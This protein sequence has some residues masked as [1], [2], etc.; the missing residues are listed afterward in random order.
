VYA[1]GQRAVRFL[2]MNFLPSET[3]KRR[4]GG[5]NSNGTI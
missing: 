2:A 1:D 3:P 4:S 5:G